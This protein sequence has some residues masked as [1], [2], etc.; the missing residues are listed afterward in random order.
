MR[1]MPN[2]LDALTVSSMRFLAIALFQVGTC[3]QRMADTAA[4]EII[5]HFLL[6]AKDSLGIQ[7]SQRCTN[8][9]MQYGRRHAQAPYQADWCCSAGIAGN[10]QIH[11][12]PGLSNHCKA[13]QHIAGM[14]LRRAQ[15]M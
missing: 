15:Q 12:A 6:D 8:I 10:D 9:V 13:Q 7:H 5:D 1:D 4:L 3:L 11:I 2:K 14:P